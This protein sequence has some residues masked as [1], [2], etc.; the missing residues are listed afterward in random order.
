M[1][2][3]G[4]RLVRQRISTNC[5]G[6]GGFVIAFREKNRAMWSCAAIS[7]WRRRIS[8]FTMQI[9]GVGRSWRRMVNALH[10]GK[11]ANTASA[12][13]YG[14]ITKKASYSV[15][16]IIKCARLKKSATSASTQFWQAMSSR[17]NALLRGLIAKCA[18]ARNRPITHR[19]G[20]SFE[21]SEK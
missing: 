15:G 14:F 3:M 18:K 4:R 13:H 7:T 12:I 21:L 5:I 10:F 1:R 16:G 8:M 17:K 9:C 11:Y 2:R 6:I 20:R 19:Y